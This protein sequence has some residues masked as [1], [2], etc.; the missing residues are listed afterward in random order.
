MHHGTEVPNYNL[1][2]WELVTWMSEDLG[3]NA[4]ICAVFEV[5]RTPQQRGYMK[6]IL[7]MVEY[8]AQ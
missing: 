2:W 6:I 7:P 4:Y 8:I 3:L 1:F 5:Y